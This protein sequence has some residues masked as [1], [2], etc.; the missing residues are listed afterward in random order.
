MLSTITV[1]STEKNTGLLKLKNDS[2]VVFLIDQKK[3]SDDDLNS[4]GKCKVKN[5]VGKICEIVNKL[6]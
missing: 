1:T 3:Y 5:S 4:R 6:G 2:I